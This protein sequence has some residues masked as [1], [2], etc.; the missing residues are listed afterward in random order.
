MLGPIIEG[1]T[2]IEPQTNHDRDRVP[3]AAEARRLTFRSRISGHSFSTATRPIDDTDRSAAKGLLV[4][5]GGPVDVY[6]GRALGPA[7]DAFRLAE[8]VIA[9][10]PLFSCQADQESI[11]RTS[12]LHN[13]GVS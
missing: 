12:G 6:F 7:T 2:A 10:S 1:W 8:N 13:I 5:A 9:A 11:A 3:L 4:N